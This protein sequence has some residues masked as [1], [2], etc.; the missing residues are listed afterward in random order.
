[1]TANVDEL[2]EKLRSEVQAVAWDALAPHAS[3]GALL[4][5]APELD[6]AT[7]AVKVA[8]DDAAAVGAWVAAGRL[9]KPSQ[10]MMQQWQ[11]EE[12]GELFSFVIVQPYVLCQRPKH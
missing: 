12:G 5:V 3:R 1:M 10:E 11:A 4:V 2:Y 7:V 8:Q 9:F 6:L